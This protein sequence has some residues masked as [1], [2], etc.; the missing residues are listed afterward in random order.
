MTGKPI[1]IVVVT[2]VLLLVLAASCRNKSKTADSC[3]VVRE[4]PAADIIKKTACNKASYQY[5]SANITATVTRKGGIPL[6]LTG[7]LRMKH[8]SIV[9]V[10][11]A[12]P[13]GIG[14]ACLLVTTDSVW[15]T[16]SI[17]KA[18]RCGK[19]NKVLE[20][21]GIPAGFASVENAIIGSGTILPEDRFKTIRNKIK[22]QG[23]I[24][25]VPMEAESKDVF[26][27]NEIQVTPSFRTSQINATCGKQGEAVLQY[28]D[29][30]ETEAGLM[31]QRISLQLYNED[32]TRVDVQYSKITINERK[33]FP[34]KVNGNYKIKRIK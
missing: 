34:F 18:C 2:S 14:S 26:S 17:E 31:P 15:M 9:W 28:Y 3:A 27:V 16:N 29:Y 21:F 22:P 33:E 12:G 6:R 1:H 24:Y 23:N 19:L 20:R 8:D 11:I 25:I 10:N 32:E 5:L 30:V 7:Q 4:M 13:L